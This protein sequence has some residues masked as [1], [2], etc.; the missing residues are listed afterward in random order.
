MHKPFHPLAQL[1]E[2][3]VRYFTMEKIPME[4]KIIAAAEERCRAL[5]LEPWEISD[6]VQEAM[7]RLSPILDPGQ[8]GL[9]FDVVYAAVSEALS[10][11]RGEE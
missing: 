11:A 7:L 6:V 8:V 10:R 5:D 4:D 2:M 1:E 3:Y 9:A